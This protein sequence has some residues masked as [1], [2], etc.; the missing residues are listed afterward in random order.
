MFRWSYYTSIW[1]D[2]NHMF[3]INL[4]NWSTL[5]QKL[6]Y[7]LQHKLSSETHLHSGGIGGLTVTPVTHETLHHMI[8]GSS[9]PAHFKVP[10]LSY[11]DD[12]YFPLGSARFS[13]LIL[14][15]PSG[16]YFVQGVKSPDP[17][18]T[19][20]LEDWSHGG[21]KPRRLKPR[22][23]KTPPTEAQKDKKPSANIKSI[24]IMNVSP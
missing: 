11:R 15:L 23:T 4:V 2:R 24:Y 3:V 17:P 16:K 12:G 20:S 10:L 1:S 18:R 7:E 5:L 13:K 8:D 9:S 14:L 22:R 21:Q 19:K 6:V